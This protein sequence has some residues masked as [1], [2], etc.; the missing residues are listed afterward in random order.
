MYIT[1]SDLK[2]FCLHDKKIEA[3]NKP[4]NLKWVPT[5]MEMYVYREE[6]V[7]LLEVGGS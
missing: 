3:T 5:Y 1:P 6:K 7:N 4:E 2:N